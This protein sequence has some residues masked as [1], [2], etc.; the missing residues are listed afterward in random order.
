M[1]FPGE[2]ASAALQAG[3]PELAGQRSKEFEL[4]DTVFLYHVIDGT[5]TTADIVGVDELVTVQ[6]EVLSLAA[7]GDSV[8]LNGE[9]AAIQLAGLEADNGLCTS[10]TVSCFH[11]HSLSSQCPFPEM[12]QP[13]C[14]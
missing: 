14:F 7:D 9:Y 1:L 2:V 4:L 8:V 11:R 13:S 12:V 3:Q 10:L 6:G 5:L